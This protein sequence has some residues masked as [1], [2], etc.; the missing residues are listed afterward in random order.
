MQEDA[1]SVIVELLHKTDR[2]EHLLHEKYNTKHE[3]SA[4]PH[5][6]HGEIRGEGGQPEVQPCPV[7]HLLLAETEG[8]NARIAP[9]PLQT[10]AQPS[11]PAHRRRT[12]A[13]PKH[14]AKKPGS[15][16]HRAVVQAAGKRLHALRGKL[17][18]GD[19]AGRND[20]AE[21]E[22]EEVHPQALRADDAP[23]GAHPDRREGGAPQVYFFL[24]WRMFRPFSY[25]FIMVRN[26]V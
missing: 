18:S 5:E 4:I 11:Q 26:I 6:L 9:L 8:W 3:V 16:D 20:A 1:K 13:D 17:V 21:K 24:G 22:G 25:F 19:D 15:G 10:P 2:E 12:E 14:A 23:R 7:I